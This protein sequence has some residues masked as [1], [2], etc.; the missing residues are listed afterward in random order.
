[1]Q[2]VPGASVPEAAA[3]L[4]ADE[5][6]TVHGTG[7]LCRFLQD[8]MDAAVESLAGHFDLAEPVRRVE[9]CLAPPGGAAAMYYTPPSEDF[10]RPGRTWY[11]T[12]GRQR[13]P[14]WLEVTTAYHEGVPGHHLQLGQTCYLGAR[15]NPFL[16]GAGRIS[17]HVEGWAVYAEKLM[18][19]LG[20]IEDPAYR[21]GMLACQAFR[22]ARVVADIGL[23]LGLRIPGDWDELPGERWDAE[24]AV[25]I[26]HSAVYRPEDFLRSEVDRYLG[27]PSQAIGY[28]VGER[29]W[30]ETREAVRRREGDRFDLRAF[31]ERAFDLGLVGLGQLQSELAGERRGAAPR[32]GQ[33]A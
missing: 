32:C 6:R 13:F 33:G 12:L 20:L 1:M 15:L 11:P 24:R 30:L 14:L 29:I 27:W 21:L 22:A 16:R 25:T 10:R 23:H 4:E 3:F 2:V 7:N 28:K 17:G 19:E 18:D 5:T 26:L 8:T 9:A 31:H